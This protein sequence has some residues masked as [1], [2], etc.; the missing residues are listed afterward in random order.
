MKLRPYQLKAEEC[1]FE[2]WKESTSTLL[3]L[4][5]G[6]GKTIV[7]SRVIQRVINETGKRAL[8]LVHRS[9]LVTQACEKLKSIGIN[10]GIEKADQYVHDNSLFDKVP[11]IVSTVQTQNSGK[12]DFSRML[13]FKPNDFALVVVDECFPTGTLVDGMPIERIRPGML[14][15]SF[16][17]KTKTIERRRVLRTMENSSSQM[18]RVNFKDNTSI[19]CTAGHPF[20]SEAKQDYIPAFNLDS[21][22]MVLR[23]AINEY[24]YLQNLSE[25]ISIKRQK[26]KNVLKDVQGINQIQCYGSNESQTRI[27][28]NE[29]QKSN[30]VSEYSGENG[31]NLA[32]YWPQACVSRWERSAS[33]CASKDASRSTWLDDGIPRRNETAKREWIPD[34]LQIRLSKSDFKN[35]DRSRWIFSRC[36]ISQKARFKKNGLFRIV[37]VESV[38]IL[39]RRSNEKFKCMRSSCFVYNLEIEGNNNYFAEGI[40]V[41]NCHHSTSSSWVK[42]IE[43]YKNNPS[44]KVLGVTATPDRTDEEALGKVFQTVAFDYEIVDA[45]HDGWLVPIKQQMVR[46]DGLDFSG[47]RTTAG[48]LNGADLAE[49]MENEK[50]LHGVTSASIEIIGDKSTI[51]FAASVKQAEM[52]AEIFNRHRPGMADWVCGM[53]KKED[54]DLKVKAFKNRETQV[55]VNVAVFTEGFDYP[56]VEIIVQASPTKSRSKYSQMVGRSTRP[57]PGIVDLYETPEERRAAIA[58]SA[59][60]HCLIVDFC[61]N[62]GKHKLVSTADIL[63]GKFTDEEIA[64]AEKRVKEKQGSADM[65]EELELAREELEAQKQEA[66]KQRAK[67]I[68]KARFS[69]VSVDPFDILQIEPERERGWDR[70]KTLSPKQNAFLL[71]NGIN[72]AERSYHANKQILV[73]LFSRMELKQA[74]Y[75]QIK[76]LQKHGYDTKTLSFNGAS[77][78]LDSLAKNGW[79][80][81]KADE[82]RAKKNNI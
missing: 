5:T 31:G 12:E 63:G 69:L 2:E 70:G 19:I 39:E 67:I 44:L 36:N 60:P 11:V 82:Y 37:G 16:N 80:K 38:E 41:H 26:N 22:D 23:L 32:I 81:Q 49:Q 78:I 14:V 6:A 34:M 42:V 52:Y 17:H 29:D 79:N 47:M 62:S 45:I 51:V 55:M 50:N 76:A 68:A 30:E 3:V 54:R 72:P 65:T 21:S 66:I 18:V 53:T 75:R 57:L 35:R 74:S 73:E 59:K 13:R 8:V 71:K 24:S 27:F 28:E 43:Y 56:G 61:G 1:I 10:V 77:Q 48:D 7:F 64:R 40:L 20:W 4:P 25:T 58:A 15:N 33:G 9:E 46:I